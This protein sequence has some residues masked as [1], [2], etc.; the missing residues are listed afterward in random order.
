MIETHSTPLEAWLSLRAQVAAAGWMLNNDILAQTVDLF[1]QNYTGPLT[2]AVLTR[3]YEREEFLLALGEQG[4]PVGLS[5]LALQQ[6]RQALERHPALRR[7][8]REDRLEE[9]TPVLLTARWLC[10]L[11][12]LRHGTV[13]IFIDP[14]WLPGHTLVQVRGLDKFEAS[15]AFDMPCAGHVTATDSV[16]QALRKELGE[17]LNLQLDD[18][19]GLRALNCYESRTGVEKSVTKI[20]E[21][22]N[23]EYRTLYSARIKAAAIQGIRFTDGEVAGLSIFNVDALRALVLRFPDRVASGL[24]GALPFYPL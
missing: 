8:F 7:W 22:V 16:D 23:I 4:K 10:H 11:A 24:S 2:P 6:A 1:I 19:E 14:A 15:G 9:G 20:L 17:E 13:E 12:G 21:P 18:L 3:E 5:A